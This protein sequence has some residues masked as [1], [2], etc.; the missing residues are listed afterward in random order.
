VAGR[1][2]GQIGIHVAVLVVYATVGYAI[3]IFFARRRFSA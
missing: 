2:P 3:A 1:L